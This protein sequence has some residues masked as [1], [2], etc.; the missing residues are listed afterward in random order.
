[1]SNSVDICQECCI[2]FFCL[3]LSY[4]SS[5][6]YSYFMITFSLHSPISVGFLISIYKHSLF[7]LFLL[8]GI[9][10]PREWSK[11]GVL[12]TPWSS[13][14]RSLKTSADV[15]NLSFSVSSLW[16]CLWTSTFLCPFCLWLLFCGVTSR[17][18]ENSQFSLYTIYVKVVF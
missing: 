18:R 2:G 6:F 13:P 9:S 8:F 17:K 11:D 5:V 10:P 7:W 4:F 15:K 3:Y 1:M 16:G 12:I 14:P